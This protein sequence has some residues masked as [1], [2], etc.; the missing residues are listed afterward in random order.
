MIPL[1]WTLVCAQNRGS[2]WVVPSVVGPGGTIP[3]G[4]CSEASRRRP[5]CRWGWG[6][7][8]DSRSPGVVSTCPD[9]DSWLV[10]GT[11]FPEEHGLGAWD[12]VIVQRVVAVTRHAGFWSSALSPAS[13]RSQLGAPPPSLLRNSSSAFAALCARCLLFRVLPAC[14][15]CTASPSAAAAPRPESVSPLASG[16]PRVPTAWPPG[17]WVWGTARGRNR[18][19][20]AGRGPGVLGAVSPAPDG[21][22]LS[23]GA[24]RGEQRCVGVKMKG[25]GPGPSRVC[26]ARAGAGVF[27]CACPVAALRAQP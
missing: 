10:D 20:G 13:G 9:L 5:G 3:Q 12:Q 24:G 27:L 8:F 16:A 19:E 4:E 17:S 1:V 22:A 23:S 15:P 14:A 18:V 6:E 2:R 25:W 21:Q 11:V 7:C 26:E